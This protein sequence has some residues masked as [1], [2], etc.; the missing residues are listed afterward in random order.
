MN[1]KELIDIY[2]KLTNR[3]DFLWNF[4]TFFVIA[5]G[6]YFISN[7]AELILTFPEKMVLIVGYGLFASMNVA[8]L[9]ITSG[10]LKAVANIIYYMATEP[11]DMA[12]VRNLVRKN[13]G[14]DNIATFLIHGTM[15]L[16]FIT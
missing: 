6:G 10:S 14:M 12:I 11:S 7:K 1:L 3:F 4:Y 2:F 15:L 8:G 16:L 5:M 13:H 9:V